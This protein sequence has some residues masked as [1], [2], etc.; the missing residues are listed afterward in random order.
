MYMGSEFGACCYSGSQACSGWIGYNQ[1]PGESGD[2]RGS[3]KGSGRLS[4]VSL[5]SLKIT[6][7]STNTTTMLDGVGQRCGSRAGFE[8]RLVH[9]CGP[10]H[11]Q[12]MHMHP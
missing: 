7:C 8:L 12:I 11:L 1:G 9:A 2:W 5:T 10:A 3:K 6:L 4:A